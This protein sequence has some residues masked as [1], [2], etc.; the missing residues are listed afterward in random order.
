MVAETPQVQRATT[1]A[2]CSTPGPFEEVAKESYYYVTP[3]DPQW[4][5]ERTESYLRFFNRYALP[6]ISAHE[7]Y[8]GH[9]VHLIALRQVGGTPLA[10]LL[11]P[12]AVTTEGW[13]H[14][15]EQ[16]M[17][18]AGY[19]E[20]EPRFELMQLR[21][22]LLRLCRY[23]VSF[24]IHLDG[25]SFEEATAFFQREGY[26]TP[27]IAERE[28]RRGVTGPNYYAY[29]LGKHEILALRERYRAAKGGDFRL[30]EFHDRFIRLPYP[31]GIIQQLMLAQE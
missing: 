5:P 28:A 29:T 27:V 17:I 21:E 23:L 6:L 25:W 11:R 16:V 7:V 14:Y 12:G 4:P 15:I 31:V 8:P 22:A 26:A 1:Q 19:G 20:E 24:G 3:P 2:A 13:A 30:Q 18:E 9:F 10:R